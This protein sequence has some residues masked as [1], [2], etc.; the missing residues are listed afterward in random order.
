MKKNGHTAAGAQRWKCTSCALSTTCP[1]GRARRHEQADEL[2]DFIAW[3][4]S[5]HTQDEQEGSA[6]AFRRRTCWCWQVPVPH[7]PVTG[8]VHDQIFIDGMHLS[9][10]WVLLIARDR[11]HVLEWQ[12][13]ANESAQAYTALLERL[14]PADVVTTDGA[15]GALAAIAHLWPST[16][17]QRCLV[18]VHRDII[19]D[20]TMHPRTEPARALLALSRR[21]T[22]I[23]S[24]DQAS[25]WLTMLH[26]FGHTFREWMSQRT[27]AA[28]DPAWASKTGKTWWY[29]HERTRRAYRRLARLARQGVL[30]TYLTN[31]DGTPAD[32][33]A[34]ATTNHVESINAVVRELLHAHRGASAYHQAVIAEWA[35]LLRTPQPPTPTEVL[36]QWEH[37]GCPTP[38]RIPTP[39][40]PNHTDQKRTIGHERGA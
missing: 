2:A 10:E 3:A 4:T 33:P 12:W 5:R 7:P 27:F 14:A 31:P 34:C 36:T 25:A 32:P 18:H 16:R 1:S 38:R 35:L 26:D 17:V 9:G 37:D 23:T 39:K 13:A 8:Q 20:L 11:E 21:L 29:T 15:A 19:R 28:Q 22:S 24:V 40:H 30:F 6:R